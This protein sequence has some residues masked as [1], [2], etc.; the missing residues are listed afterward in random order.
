MNTKKC[1]VCGEYLS[2][3]VCGYSD[4]MTKDQR[5][6]RYNERHDGRN[7]QRKLHE[8]AGKTNDKTRVH[9]S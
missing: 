3:C 8:D 2:N 4:V 7:S 6:E 1:P 5:R 9:E